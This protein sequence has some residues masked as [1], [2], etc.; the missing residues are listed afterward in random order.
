MA[1]KIKLTQKQ[2]EEFCNKLLEENILL[3]E[4]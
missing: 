1:K 2:L 3:D 4:I